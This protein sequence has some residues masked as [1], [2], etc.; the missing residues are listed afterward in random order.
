MAN[1]NVYMEQGGDTLVVASGGTIE[2]Q[3]GA[4]LTDSRFS[5]STTVAADALVIP[6]THRMVVKTTGADAEA[7][8]LANGVA[9]QRLTVTLGTDGGGTGTLTPATATGFV[10]VA[11]ADAGDTATFEYVD[12]T[13]GW[14]LVGCYGATAQPTVALS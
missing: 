3:S 13:A 10:S 11:F 12:D 5:G 2:M 7:L 14:I 9:G 1:T 8:T 6:V 4:T